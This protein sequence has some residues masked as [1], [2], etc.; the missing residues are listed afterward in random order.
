MKA[1]AN[2][3]RALSVLGS[4]CRHHETSTYNESIDSD[5][6][7]EDGSM[8]RELTYSNLTSV[9]E[10]LFLVFM[11]KNESQIK[12]AALRGL[13]GVFIARPREILRLDQT[14]LISDVMASDSPLNVQLESLVCWRDILLVSMHIIFSLWKTLDR[15]FSSNYPFVDGRSKDRKW[16]SQS[17]D[18]FKD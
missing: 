4:V 12:C 6:D 1:K 10:E 5:D 2:V 17:Q 9:F 13:C 3:Q 11:S 15:H 14:G 8:H 16:G 18:G 7:E